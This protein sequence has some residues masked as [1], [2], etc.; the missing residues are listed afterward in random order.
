MPMVDDSWKK[1]NYNIFMNYKLSTKLMTAIFVVLLP[2]LTSCDPPVPIEV[3]NQ[4]DQ[5]ITIFVNANRYFQVPAHTTIRG[6]TAII[7]HKIFFVEAMTAANEIVYSR[8]FTRDELIEEKRKVIIPQIEKDPYLPLE[9]ENRT[10]NY[11]IEVEVEST[12]IAFMKANSSVRKRPLPPDLDRY[13]VKVYALKTEGY[14]DW[15]LIYDKIPLRVDLERANWKLIIA[16][17]Q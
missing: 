1:S 12:P 15:V 5:S 10:N 9:I 11:L 13:S 2:L 7:I 4:T 14:P 3:E 17:S 16:S 8:Y 6:D